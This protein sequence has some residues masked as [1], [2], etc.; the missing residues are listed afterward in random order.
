[1]YET[2]MHT[3][4]VLNPVPERGGAQ[5]ERFD[6]FNLLVQVGTYE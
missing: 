1:M 6:K 3:K 5:L 2:C 4:Y